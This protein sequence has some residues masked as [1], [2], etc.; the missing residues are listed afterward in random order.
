MKFPSLSRRRKKKRKILGLK[1]G[2]SPLAWSGEGL[3]K[4]NACGNSVLLYRMGKKEESPLYLRGGRGKKKKKRHKVP[5][6]FPP[7]AMLEQKREK[8]HFSC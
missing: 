5:G 7:I 6:K 3:Q 1:T 4:R 2:R 8:N